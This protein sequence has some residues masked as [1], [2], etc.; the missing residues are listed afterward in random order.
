MKMAP[1]KAAAYYLSFHAL[2]QFLMPIFLL[3]A[4]P[5]FAQAQGWQVKPDFSNYDF[6]RGAFPTPDGG[7][8][9][10]G[11]TGAT[12]DLHDAYLLKLDP[13]GQEQWR[14]L[15][16]GPAHDEVDGFAQTNDGGYI[17][18]G[19]TFMGNNSDVWLVKTD[20]LG[21]IEWENT[22]GTTAFE[23][24]RSVIQTSDGGFAVIGRSDDGSD[25][26]I[27]LLKTD[28]LGNEEWSN[29]YGGPEEDQGW[30]LVEVAG[31]QIVLVGT[32]ASL[33]AGMEDIYLAK[34]G[35][36]GSFQWFQTFGGADSDLGF[37]VLQ[38][39]DGC[40]IVGGAT[41]SFGAGDYDVYLVKASNDGILQWSQTFGGAFGEWGAFVKEM[42][43]GGYALVGSAQSFNNFFDDIY[44]L[45]TDTDGN[46]IWHNTYIQDKRDVPH[47]LELTP[48][49]GFIIAGHSR[50]D[51]NGII[52]T[53]QSLVMRMNANGNLL[54]NY[55]QGRIFHDLDLDCEF[56]QNEPGFGSWMLRASNPNQT[57]Y[58]L[59]DSDGF[60]SILTDTGTYSLQL[61]PP[62]SYWLSCENDLSQVFA[63]TFDTLGASFPLQAAYDCPQMEVDVATGIVQPCKSAI[64]DVR[65]R[66]HGTVAAA[67]AYVEITLDA[68]LSFVSATIPAMPLPGNT[69]RF[70]IGDLEPGEGGR[71][72]ME[73]FLVCGAD[74]GKT[75]CLSAHI[76]P[77]ENCLP[78]DP[79]WNES[80]IELKGSC[81]GDSVRFVAKNVGSGGMNEPQALIVIEDQIVGRA[82]EIQLGS[83][84]SLV[85]MHPAFGKTIR[86]E[87]EQAEGHPGRSQPSVAVEGCSQN[88]GN[89]NLGNV[90][91]FPED[92]ADAFK[93]DDCRESADYLLPNEKLAF[94]KGIG[95]QH[96]IKQETDIEYLIYFK[97]TGEGTVSQVVVQ[98]T[99]SHWLDLTTLRPGSASHPYQMAI[100]NTGILQFTFD[101]IQL[102][103]SVANDSV[104][105]GFV[106]FRVSQ[107]PDVPV[108]S[109]I[110]NRSCVTFDY[111]S[112][113]AK[114]AYFHTIKKPEVISI[115]DVSLCTGGLYQGVAYQSDTAFLQSIALPN[116][117][118]LHFT[119]ITTWPVYDLTFQDST[120]ANV[121]YFFSGQWL[122]APGLYEDS[123]LA[124]TLGCDSLITLELS[125]IPL[126][127]IS[128]DTAIAI[129]SFFLGH[130]L[131]ADTLLVDTV[132][133][134]AGCDTVVV[135]GVDVF[136]R[137]EE[138]FEKRL[139]L[140]VFP[141]PASGDFFVEM[142]LPEAM[143]MRI[144]T[145]DMLGRR[146]AVI[147]ENEFFQKGN[148]QLKI[149]SST[150]PA[151]IYLLHFQ[152][153]GHSFSKK[154]IKQ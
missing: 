143:E 18:V 54:S 14:K 48:D 23:F 142:D 105:D 67:G 101:N 132:F 69:W 150:W 40:L 116:I 28:G 44:L 63:S 36:D 90:T 29:I 5:F 58:G 4:V 46:E 22:Y 45:R 79:Q 140:Q 109:Q 111:A 110:L 2:G 82:I 113:Q 15:F 78:P 64:Y 75:H 104:A 128:L 77:D 122:T 62:N 139:N 115:S 145:L 11:H 123:T 74:L 118:S 51:T 31:Q 96:L 59:T 52:E 30:G 133:S 25:V 117:D 108:D 120:C 87:T 85:V 13:F 103:D 124:T 12:N 17:L 102:A 153:N 80:S 27:F 70:D 152:T 50:V 147:S 20:H 98:D 53:S 49:E 34:V 93:S 56:D 91:M 95:N 100:S 73:T 10:A 88:V 134:E 114:P 57:F 144:E 92:D 89:I 107:L 121:P 39:S 35:L 61:I 66:N 1:K 21:N 112:P 151:G 24:G 126:L 37:S 99:L 71:F 42:P 106:K 137:T 68:N 83:D 131:F 16:G 33:G 65:F 38:A 47:S 55:L 149:N 86:L 136:T 135:W 97:N 32:T 76:F 8:I 141:N 154:I 94:P 6:A 127:Q 146:A 3:L 130:Q 125:T 72:E 41:R 81:Q 26:G 129:G 9:V 43:S 148:H 138:E 19:S 7:Y 119:Q 60:Y 84:D